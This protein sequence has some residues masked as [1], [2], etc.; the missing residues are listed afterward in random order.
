MGTIKAFSRNIYRD[1]QRA[2]SNDLLALGL[3][4]TAVA[5][6]ADLT[7]EP[8]EKAFLYLP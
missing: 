2:F 1:T 4:Q 3:A 7:L 6:K 5:I 8:Q